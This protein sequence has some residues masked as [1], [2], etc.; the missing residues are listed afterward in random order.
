M[1]QTVSVHSVQGGGGIERALMLRRR[2]GSSQS[3]T[4]RA[5]F[6][7]SSMRQPSGRRREFAREP[8]GRLRFERIRCCLSQRDRTWG[9]RTTGVRNQLAPV[10]TRSSIIRVWQREPRGRSIAVK[11][12][13]DERMMLNPPAEWFRKGNREFYLHKSTHAVGG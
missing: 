6:C 9:I 11:N 1:P 10:K 13:W 8:T 7:V 3:R 2:P 5:M 4:L 12:C